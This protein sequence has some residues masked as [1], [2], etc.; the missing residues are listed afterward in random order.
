M[1]LEFL[2]QCK[3]FK[4]VGLKQSPLFLVIIDDTVAHTSHMWQLSKAGRKWK[5]SNRWLE[6]QGTADRLTVD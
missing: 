1:E 3:W 4:K 6:K 5:H 2:S